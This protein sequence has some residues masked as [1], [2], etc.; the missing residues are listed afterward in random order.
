MSD[1]FALAALDGGP[2]RYGFTRA[3][4][5]SNVFLKQNPNLYGGQSA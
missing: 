4:D 1:L 3:E 2:G 5:L